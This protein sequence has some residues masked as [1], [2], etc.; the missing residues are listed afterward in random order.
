MKRIREAG[1]AV[2]EL[3]IVLLILAALVGGGYWV[4]KQRSD[5]KD[6][7]NTTNTTQEADD[8]DT[9]TAPQVNDTD[10]LQPAEKALDDTNLDASTEDGAELDSQTSSF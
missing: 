9:A 7:K 8:T 4:Y 1:F 10:D 6:Y 3:V 5:D 2:V